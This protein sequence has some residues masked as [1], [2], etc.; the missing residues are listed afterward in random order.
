MKNEMQLSNYSVS[1]KSPISER[2]I[3]KTVLDGRSRRMYVRTY[4]TDALPN[5]CRPMLT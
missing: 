2:F 1:E 5:S 3:E 4:P